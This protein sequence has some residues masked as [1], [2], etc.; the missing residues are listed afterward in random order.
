MTW[1]KVVKV[2]PHRCDKPYY[3]NEGVVPGEV[4]A[5]DE[6]GKQWECIGT[7]YG[8]QWDPYPRGILKWKVR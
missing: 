8:V 4:I 2:D 1:H 6:C 5:C 7:D 3:V